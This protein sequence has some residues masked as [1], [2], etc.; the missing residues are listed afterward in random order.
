MEDALAQSLREAWPTAPAGMLEG[1]RL[2][3]AREDGSDAIIHDGRGL[4]APFH[5]GMRL[6]TS[7]GDMAE[8]VLALEALVTRTGDACRELLG[9]TDR[10]G[11]ITD[12]V[13]I[14]MLGCVPFSIRLGRGGRIELITTVRV[15]MIGH[16]GERAIAEYRVGGGWEGKTGWNRLT[17]QANAQAARKRAAGRMLTTDPVMASCLRSMT[18]QTRRK[19][20][21]LLHVHPEAPREQVGWA[22]GA[23][24][25][26]AALSMRGIAIDPRIE[27]IRV[28][29]RVVIGRVRL[30]PT[31]TW[32]AGTMLAKA[33]A[34]PDTVLNGVKGRP[35]SDVVAHPLLD[36]AI[37]MESAR[38]DATGA[39]RVI[40][41]YGQVEL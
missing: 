11:R 37:I 7:G 30:S 20:L 33:T 6:G 10:I 5:R 40:A 29:N 31:T 4:P 19:L 24:W 8:A 32:N 18:D 23:N 34:L 39:L 41:R 25:N 9:V 35:L 1:G 26:E 38:T 3:I 22:S 36:E 16:S 13:D 15:E 21:D 12:P 14:R 28:K 17:R 2:K 27:T